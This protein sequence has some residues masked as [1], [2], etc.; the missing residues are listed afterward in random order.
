MA[1]TSPAHLIED[2]SLAEL[3]R[4]P[5][6]A[7][8]RL[9]R[10]APVAKIASAGVWFVTRFADCAE[11]GKG[12][13][14]FVGATSHPTLQRVFGEPNVLTASGRIHED[15]R[16]G[17]DPK[18]RPA[19]VGEY[20][21]D[22]VRPLARAYL[23]RMLADTALTAHG[24]DDTVTADLMSAYF[25][26]VSVEALRH[27][28]GLDTL[29]DATTLRRWFAQLN[30]GVANFGRDPELFAVADTATRE[31]E[32]VLR[33]RLDRLRSRPDDSMLSHLLWAGRRD[34]SPRTL[35]A[36]LPSLKVILLGGMQEP[37]HAAGSTLLGLFGE[38]E[39][40][41]RV[42]RSPADLVPLAV[43]EGLRW[44][45]PI[46]AVERQA[47]KDV[48]VAGVPIP[49]G[50]IVQ[51][52]LASA[53]R[54]E[55]HF[56]DPDRFDLDRS[57]RTHQAFGNGEHFCAGHFFA[58]QVERIMLEELAATL[59]DLSPDPEREP[60]VSGWVFRAPKVLPGRWTARPPAERIEVTSPPRPDA[61]RYLI[62]GLSHPIDDVAVLTLR[63][64]GGGPAAE[65]KPGA[66]VDLWTGSERVRQ[67]SLC[68]DP[69]NRSELRIAVLREV[70]GRG[71]SGYVH[72]VLRPGMAVWITG[73][74]NHF[75]LIHAD[76]YLLI[77]GG[78]G[79]TPLLP[80]AAELDR[81]AVSWTLVYAGR[82]RARM[83]FLDELGRFGGKVVLH[84]TDAL[85]RPD[86]AA[87]L[88]AHAGPGTVVYCCGPVGLTE[89][90][91]GLCEA[92]GV[93]LRVERFAGQRSGPRPDDQPFE[94][95]LAR[96]GRSVPVA[97]DETALDALHDAGYSVPSACREG[98][99]GT[100]ELRVLSGTVDH[101][102]VLLTAGQR[103]AG[104]RML[105]CVS[106]AVDR[107]VV[108]L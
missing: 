58:R 61:V 81:R 94:M 102:D 7:Y 82:S 28:M 65:W 6:P 107:L 19:S 50:D 25:E 73:P 75:E 35:E 40:F 18:L 67:Y 96:G 108:D 8:R 1:A 68:G 51:L 104:N 46:G 11:L 55:G 90:A 83:A 23:D 106:R 49:A 105:P 59:P 47:S 88:A 10:A 101:R 24:G 70:A 42:W 60:V 15:L 9:R 45:A 76:R 66:H 84:P 64:A 38:P 87:L 29:V 13:Y 77:A 78:I 80:I 48:T 36:L 27:V 21:D 53:N 91:A 89:T 32:E 3:D 26:P 63:P 62:T 39:Q 103:A 85:G 69:A 98:T 20:V 92:L 95:L 37:G 12:N 93:P 56:E 33:P 16:E 57:A 97:A 99:C 17:I 2:I 22:Q 4:D 100:C 72:E 5:Y 30:V 71:G 43:H 54:D 74:R 41:A 14:G 86:L 31:I 79:I 52:I 44:I 34:G